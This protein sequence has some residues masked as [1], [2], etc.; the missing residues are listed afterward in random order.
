[1]AKQTS[2][3]P[4]NR[5]NNSSS[6]RKSSSGKGELRSGSK[7]KSAAKQTSRVKDI[8]M[9]VVIA[10]CILSMIAIF[11]PAIPWLKD[12]LFFLFGLLMYVAPI[13]IVALFLI[14]FYHDKGAS[15]VRRLI[16]VILFL[17]ALS[18]IFS[19]AVDVP[20][21]GLLG[22]GNHAL[23]HSWLGAAGSYVIN[24]LL[25]AISIA[26]FIDFSIFGYL[27]DR[28]K[29]S[30]EKRELREAR[31]ERRALEREA[32]EKE[33]R[34]QTQQEI[35]AERKKALAYQK[36][37]DERE[38]QER[39]NR[40]RFTTHY[41]G[42][43]DTKIVDVGPAEKT[44]FRKSDD[45]PVR[46][47]SE[48]FKK[49]LEPDTLDNEDDEQD[50][51]F[52]ENKGVLK[53]AAEEDDLPKIHFG[54]QYFRKSEPEES[55]VSDEEPDSYTKVVIT[56]NGK[57]IPV[58]TEGDV[59]SK[60][61]VIQGG[62]VREPDAKTAAAA[63]PKQTVKEP[64]KETP[65][66]EQM[67]IK[68]VLEE[69]AKEY[70]FPPLRL[71]HHGVSS[72]ASKSDLQRELNDNASKLKQ[73]FETFGVG[74]TVT[75][76][77]CGPSVTR[78]E[79]QP[80]LGVKVSKV[81]SL[82]D[83]IKLSLAA[84]DIRIEA[85]IP[86]KAAIGIEIPNKHK[87]GVVLRDLLE[88]DEY[89]DSKSKLS[90]GLG[91]DVDGHTIISDLTKMPHLLVAGTTG[92]G[93][94]VCLNTM[95]MSILYHAKP[96]EVKMIM[97]DPKMVEFAQYN[98]IPH[99]LLPVVTD[100][101]K[102]SMAL[103]WAVA[104]MEKRY[105]LFAKYGVRNIE[106]FNQY[107]EME[108]PEDESGIQ[109]RP[110]PLIVV[111]VDEFADMMMVAAKEVEE[112]V[113]RLA[114]KARA[115]GIHLV[116]AT[117]SPRADVLTGLIKANI[118]SRIALSVSSGLES[119]IIIDMNGAETLLGHG[120]MLYLPIGASKP[121]RVQGAYI[122]EQEI[123]DVVTYITKAGPVKG[124]GINESVDL[125][126]SPQEAAQAEKGP[127][128]GKDELFETVGRFVIEKQKA[129]IG[130]LQRQFSIGFNRAARIMDQLADEGVVGEEEG[131]KPRRILMNMV[132]FEELLSR[133]S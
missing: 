88:S 112:S 57:V 87:T 122:S 20:S 30:E 72:S 39:K 75:N 33:L 130:N 91:R 82:Q 84:A 86:G 106:G 74:I 80:D 36:Y 101:K 79:I 44:V 70:Q 120:D 19:F 56:K 105:E 123:K 107:I 4:S 69:T 76:I 58:E 38:E 40:E 29:Q 129:S 118:P 81:L 96:T 47:A 52:E 93:K 124:G 126:R 54:E 62:A 51:P 9:L 26:L 115:A 73:T 83:D 25:I 14:L 61:E 6:A 63:V 60:K 1:M 49:I 89:K 97:I 71:L 100:P 43:G 32:E 104:E 92:S 7:K 119:R 67:T 16:A 132:E 59:L 5:N 17:F 125:T 22:R 27:K 99:L 110:M 121:I 116:L 68:Q 90:Y 35:D 98:G 46:S 103:S 34:H 3:K 48:R 41:Y 94:S 8:V 12:G 64:V 114:Q 31:R 24:G 108:Q 53:P 111:F 127:A 18:G 2:S 10:V 21:G 131:T 133:L 65:S 128:N 78:Y 37:I 109:V 85:P 117:Q 113:C 77:S 55:G 95:I 23:F 50:L 66:G 11:S 13:L 45:D 102:A 42:I 28:T 15:F